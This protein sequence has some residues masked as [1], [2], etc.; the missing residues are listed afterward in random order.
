MQRYS[1]FWMS[2]ARGYRC[3]A[4][5]SGLHGGHC[6]GSMSIKYAL[7]TLDR[8]LRTA[9]ERAKVGHIEVGRSSPES[10]PGGL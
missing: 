7:Q 6:R 5:L 2:G 9:D 10:P 8:R 1:P 4:G 3:S